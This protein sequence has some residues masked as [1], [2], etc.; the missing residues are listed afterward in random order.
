MPP[1]LEPKR[2]YVDPHLHRDLKV[3]AADAGLSM[4]DYIE[5]ILREDI[6]RLDASLS[7]Q[8]ELIAAE[9]NV[10]LNE[11]AKDVLRQ[12]VKSVLNTL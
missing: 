10:S 4:Q 3:K 7:Q 8:L 12:H 5:K 1:S 2:L 6:L 11:Y 9:N